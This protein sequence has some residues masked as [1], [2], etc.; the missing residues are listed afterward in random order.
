MKTKFNLGDTVYRFV[1]DY[2]GYHIRNSQVIKI[3]ITEDSNYYT[4]SDEI[5]EKEDV[6]FGSILKAIETL[7]S[8]Y[9]PQYKLTRK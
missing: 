6:L 4:L 2:N 8:Q 7:V 1:C 3:T 5:T 9:L